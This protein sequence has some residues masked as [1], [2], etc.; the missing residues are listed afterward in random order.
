MTYQEE[1]TMDQVIERCS[2]FDVHQVIV[3]VYVRA[4][5]D[6]GKRRQEV[7]PFGTMTAELLALRD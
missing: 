4:P 1:D 6:A 7:C 3:A 5:R 2:G